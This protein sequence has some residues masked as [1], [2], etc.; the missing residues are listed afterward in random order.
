MLKQFDNELVKAVYK[1]GDEHIDIA[2]EGETVYGF[3]HSKHDSFG[4]TD[5]YT[6]NELGGID[7]LKAYEQSFENLCVYV[8]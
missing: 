1:Y 3:Y 8:E 4:V 2:V 5:F 7:T 6:L